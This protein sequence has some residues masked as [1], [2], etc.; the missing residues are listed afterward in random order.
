[1]ATLLSKEKKAAL[2]ALD[3]QEPYVSMD[4]QPAVAAYNEPTV[5]QYSR[6]SI[7]EVQ[8]VLMATDEWFSIEDDATTDPNCR[9]VYA[10]LTAKF[11]DIDIQHPQVQK[12]LNGLVT[13]T[14]IRTETKEMIDSLGLRMITP[15]QDIGISK[16]RV[17]HLEEARS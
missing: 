7:G 10:M 14:Y 5:E 6:V 9:R 13:I 3:A 8:R 11:G 4:L 12:V 1:M 15:G 16:V 2:K 17:G